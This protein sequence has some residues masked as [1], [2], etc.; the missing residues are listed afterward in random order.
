MELNEANIAIL[1]EDLYEDLELW[2]PYYRLKEAGAEVEVLGT[3]ESSYESK[4]GYG[5]DVDADVGDANPSAYDAVVVPGGYAP[6]RMRRHEPMIEFVADTW[7]EGA[8]CAAIC[9]A[10]WVPASADIVDG[11]ELTSF[12]AIRD[13]MENAGAE[14]VDREVVRDGR[15]ITSRT[16]DDLPAFCST[17]I[18]ALK[19]RE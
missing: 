9:H 5:V 3:G 18:G 6:D 17:L 8:L 14:W 4:H 19:E 11:K 10:G 12:Y 15:L 16:P 2:Y 13:D 1:A 7:D